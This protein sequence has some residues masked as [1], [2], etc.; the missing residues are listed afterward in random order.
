MATAMVE[1][2]GLGGFRK[3]RVGRNSNAWR[4][5]TAVEAKLGLGGRGHLTE[6]VGRGQKMAL[7]PV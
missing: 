6:P 1:V 2:E 3:E 5:R 7:R 4:S